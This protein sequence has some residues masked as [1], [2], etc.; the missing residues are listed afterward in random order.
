MKKGY[1]RKRWRW[2]PLLLLMLVGIGLLDR[3]DPLPL[4]EVQPAR[5]VVAEDGTPLWRFADKQ[6]IWRY[7]VTLEEVS[8]EYIQALLTYEDRWFW[9]HPGINPIAIVRAI[10]QNL[11]HHGIVS[12][13]S[14]LTM[15]VARLIDPQPR[16]LRGKVVQAW[17]ALQLEWHLSKRDILT[18]YLNR[19]PFGG[20]VEGIGAASWMWLGKPPSQL[21]K[22]EAA[23]LAVLP[24]APS[25]LRPDRW[26][27]RA[28]A[29]R[30]KV[31][32]RLAEYQV[33]SAQDVAEIKQE[34]VWLPPRQVPQMAPL[35]ARRLLSLSPDNKIRSTIDVS[36][37][38]E[39][40]SLASSLKNQLP[41]RTSLALLVV[42][43]RSMKVRGYVGSVSFNDDS[44][45]GHVDMIS[46]VRSPG[47]VL[48]PLFTAWRWMRG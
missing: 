16:T 42:D 5:V 46:S 28:E 37:Q 22:G 30:N 21:T 40:E 39:L 12:G 20:T 19:A 35:L 14:T 26:P 9:H 2:L 17:R 3:L 7:P 48:K 1:A 36:L 38:R 31:L 11:L 6:G 43:H 41:P 13:G 4:Q 24:Q 29:A 44:R 15:Q 10:G 27:Q 45:F 32:D 8:P 18:L 25:R 23:L 47:S 34:A 33:W